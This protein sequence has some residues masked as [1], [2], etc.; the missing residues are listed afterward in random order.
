MLIGLDFFRK[1][2]NVHAIACSLSII[3]L[4]WNDRQP[5]LLIVPV[6]EVFI[7]FYLPL[8]QQYLCSSKVFQYPAKRISFTQIL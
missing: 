3:F 8:N 4:P 6:R 7:F 5:Y 2:G 1:V